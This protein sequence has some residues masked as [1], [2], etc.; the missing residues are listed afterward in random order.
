[1][2]KRHLRLLHATLRHLSDAALMR[3]LPRTL[4]QAPAAL[5]E[6]VL[7]PLARRVAALG[8]SAAWGLRGALA[9]HIRCGATGVPVFK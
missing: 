4:A 2:T 1:M 6:A 5:Q 7:G 8:G 9:E 3:E